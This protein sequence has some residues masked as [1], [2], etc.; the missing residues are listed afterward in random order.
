M[1]NDVMTGSEKSDRL[2][3]FKAIFD[4][5]FALLAILDDRGSVAEVNSAWKTRC[6]QTPLVASQVGVG[7]DYLAFL[8]SSRSAGQNGRSLASELKKF[9]N[10]KQGKE[11][12]KYSFKNDGKVHW[13][14]CLLADC[15]TNDGKK[16]IAVAHIDLSDQVKAEEALKE[17]LDGERDDVMAMLAH[18][19]KTP[20][21]GMERTIDALTEGHFGPITAEQQLALGELRRADQAIL[22]MVQNLVEIYKYER[23]PHALY[24]MPVRV[25]TVLTNAVKDVETFSQPKAINFV[26]DV[27]PDVHPVAADIEAITRVFVNLLHNAVKFSDVGS[28]ITLIGRNTSDGVTISVKDFGMGIMESDLPLLFTR[29]GQGTA[30][31]R[32][33]ASVGLGLYICKQILTAHNGTITCES[34]PSIGTTMSVTLPAHLGKQSKNG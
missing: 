24:I 10:G 11:T 8:E 2:H 28:Q 32:Y 21:I 19:L 16:Y 25:M 34:E 4:S 13:Y 5:Q 27:S 33:T 31:K 23:D 6:A 3:L 29:F 7:T 9:L 12:I 17:K 22:N 20:L 18:D 1:R 15:S 26:Y 14:L 30:G